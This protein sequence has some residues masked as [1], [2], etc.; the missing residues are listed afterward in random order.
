M[1]GKPWTNEALQSFFR[2]LA[3]A[4]GLR[5]GPSP[6]TLRHTAASWLADAGVPEAVVRSILGHAA[7]SMTARYTHPSEAALLEALGKLEDVETGRRAPAGRQRDREIL[8]FRPVES[9]LSAT[10]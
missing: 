10:G 9:P 5:T 6:H 7:G 2:S 4:S 3:L 8:V 1:R